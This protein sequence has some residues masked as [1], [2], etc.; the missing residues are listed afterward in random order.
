MVPEIKYHVQACRNIQTDRA[1]VPVVQAT[2][3]QRNILG[4]HYVQLA[5][6]PD[7]ILVQIGHNVHQALPILDV[8]GISLAVDDL[9]V[10][11]GF[12]DHRHGEADSY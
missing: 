9:L 8:A 6:L 10:V 1:F 12:M 11:R 4:Q 3:I 2:L 7:G 5:E